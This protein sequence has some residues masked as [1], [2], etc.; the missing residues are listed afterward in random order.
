MSENTTNHNTFGSY[1]GPDYQQKLVWQLLVEPEWCAKMIDFI[2]IDYFDDPYLKRIFIIMLEYYKENEKVPNLQNESIYG[3][4]YKH[5]S[6]TSEVEGDILKEKV[7]QIKLW[8]DR[9]INHNLLY[10]GDVVRKEALNFVKQ[11]EYRKIGE[12]IISETKKGGIRRPD[13][14]YEI[15]EKFN[16]VYNIGDEEDYGTDVI[17]DIDKA[18]SKEFRETIPTG[19]E[20][21]DSV[22][23]N[24]L[25]KGEIGLILAPSGVG[26]TT[27]LTKIANNAFNEGKRVLQIIFEDTIAQVQRKH[28]ALWSKIK[29]S[30]MDENTELVKERVL[31][32]VRGKKEKGAKI[33]FVKFNDEDTTMQTIKNWI[34][35]QEKKFGYKYDLI[36]L[37]YLDCVEP[38]KR[39]KDLHAAELSVVKSF[40]A[41]AA[42][43]NIPCWSAIQ[44]NR[45]G[46]NIDFVEAHHSGGNIKRI[47]KSHFVMSVSKPD[48][49][50]NIAN[51]KILK[52]RFARDGHEFK[53][54]IFNNDTLEIRITDKK[55]LSGLT[56]KKYDDED[57]GK[58][59]DKI[60]SLKL[61]SEGQGML[62]SK[63]SEASS[64]GPTIQDT[65]DDLKL[66]TNFDNEANTKNDEE[67]DYLENS[68][69]QSDGFVEK[70]EEKYKDEEVSS[71]YDSPPEIVAKKTYDM[72][73]TEQQF[74]SPGV[75]VS[76]GNITDTT[77]VQ[78]TPPP[79]I[80][81]TSG[82]SIEA[83]ISNTSIDINENKNDECLS[84]LAEKRQE[85]GCIFKE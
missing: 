5:K 83:M 72:P 73:E 61:N 65:N 11:Q 1:Y 43:Y 14:T 29:L 24:G 81:S 7:N 51:I 21:I 2:S 47:Q 55:Y 54:C 9:V 31:N 15:E 46:F 49:S 52:A 82:M 79:S 57:L 12:E 62:H 44:T 34:A 68:K 66:N 27:A 85:Q 3:A 71:H 37:D 70:V 38:N 17:D 36:V 59:E 16:K 20:V 76:E 78:E 80:G 84:F 30:E 40:I 32:H 8:N 63:L 60:N 42:E 74:T 28:F 45:S 35:R 6:P 56:A 69:S 23:G 77:N 10:D 39:E 41:M 64:D 4:I 48:K 33:E 58:M 50:S 75:S 22:T 53:D 18:L 19:I 25:G 26:K 67:K 13:F